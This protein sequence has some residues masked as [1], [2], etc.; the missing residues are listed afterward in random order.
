MVGE[1]LLCTKRGCSQQEA[2]TRQNLKQESQQYINAFLL[3]RGQPMADFSH[4]HYISAINQASLR[5][6]DPMRRRKITIVLE[7]TYYVLIK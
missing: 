1:S 3:S 5:G 4:V 2:K 6:K 7:V